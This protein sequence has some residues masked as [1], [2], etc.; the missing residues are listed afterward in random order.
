MS[1]QAD[2]I[3]DEAIDYAD[4]LELRRM[5]R[6]ARKF[7]I[8][9]GIEWPC[10]HHREPLNTHTIGAVSQCKRCR[11]RRW[12]KGFRLAVRR[13]ELKREIAGHRARSGKVGGEV[14]AERFR[15]ALEELTVRP[16]NGRYPLDVMKRQTAL[17]FGIT[18]Q[19]LVGPSHQPVFVHARAVLTKILRERGLS[20]PQIGMLLG[21]RDHT[22]IINS[23]AKFD[24]YCAKNPLVEETYLA[25]RDAPREAVED[26]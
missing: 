16:D 25:L 8:A 17:R 9:L 10:G 5:N 2:T 14:I 7:N 3:T 26:D 6:S 13:I 22:S 11:R 24:I 23:V 21:G 12:M 19:A 15:Q 20:Y 18:P 1:S 4:R